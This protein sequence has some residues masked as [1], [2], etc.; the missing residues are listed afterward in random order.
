[1]VYTEGLGEERPSIQIHRGC[2]RAVRH[3]NH[4]F[5][6]TLPEMSAAQADAEATRLTSQMIN[7]ESLRLDITLN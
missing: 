5:I 2:A 7:I 1:M 4:E 3:Y 6:E